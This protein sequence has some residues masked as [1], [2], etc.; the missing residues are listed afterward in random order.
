LGSS[1]NIDGVLEPDEWAGAVQD[2]LSDDGELL[3]MHDGEYLY[4]GIRASVKGSGVG[5]I[6][7][8]RGEQV[9]IL[10]SSA[11]LGTSIYEKD[12]AE[13]QQTQEFVWQCRDTGNGATAQDERREFLQAERWLA[14]NGRMGVPEEVEYQIAMP[15]G[16]LRLAVTFLGPPAFDSVAVWPQDLGDGCQNIELI[17]GPI[18]ERLQFSPQ[19]WVT[20]SPIDR[21]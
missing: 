15:E 14:N 5:S 8:D 6:C 11:A 10:H 16:S 2:K 4:I 21:P 7:I 18:P 9:A 3:L 1:P 17:T 19:T 13:W 12:G 20:V